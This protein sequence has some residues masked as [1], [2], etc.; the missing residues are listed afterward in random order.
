[1]ELDLLSSSRALSPDSVSSDLDTSLLRDW[2]LDFRASSPNSAASVEKCS[3]S[4]DTMCVQ[5]NR[6]HCNYYLSYSEDR[7]VSPQSSLSE[8][9]FSDVSIKDLFNDSRPESPDLVPSENRF[10]ANLNTGR[11]SHA[12]PFPLADLSFLP[13]VFYYLHHYKTFISTLFDPL[14]K[15][16]SS[17]FEMLLKFHAEQKSFQEPQT[18][19][20][21]FALKRSHEI[22]LTDKFTP[23]KYSAECT[24]LPYFS[25]KC[26]SHSSQE[27]TFYESFSQSHNFVHIRD[28]FQCNQLSKSIS[29]SPDASGLDQ[30][31]F[32]PCHDDIKPDSP[33]FVVFDSVP[34]QNMAIQAFS[35]CN[36][37]PSTHV[38][39]DSVKCLKHKKSEQCLIYESVNKDQRL[40]YEPF[41][42]RLTAHIY[43]PV[44]R[45]KHVCNTVRFSVTDEGFEKTSEQSNV[46]C[47]TAFGEEK[48]IQESTHFKNINSIKPRLNDARTVNNSQPELSYMPSVKDNMDICDT[49]IVTEAFS[50]Q[51]QTRN[52]TME[53]RPLLNE[54]K[55]T[56]T[57][58]PFMMTYSHDEFFKDMPS[59]SLR[60][61]KSSF[62]PVST[63]SSKINLS[64]HKEQKDPDFKCSETSLQSM[65]YHAN[66]LSENVAL[67][68][69]DIFDQS[70]TQSEVSL[71][72]V[73]G[74]TKTME[75]GL[76]FLAQSEGSSSMTKDSPQD[77]G[78][79]E[80][81]TSSNP[82]PILPGSVS[83]QQEYLLSDLQEMKMTQDEELRSNILCP[84]LSQPHDGISKGDRIHECNG[85]QLEVGCPK[86]NLSV[87][88]QREKE[89]I[90]ASITWPTRLPISDQVATEEFS[91]DPTITQSTPGERTNISPTEDLSSAEY[92]QRGHD[93]LKHSLSF[94]SGVG[95]PI[96][97]QLPENLPSD[98]CE[99]YLI[100]HVVQGQE[101]EPNL[102]SCE[103]EELTRRSLQE[104]C[105]EMSDLPNQEA[106]ISARRSS[107]EELIPCS[108]SAKFEISSNEIS[109]V[110]CVH[111]PKTA[112]SRRQVIFEDPMQPDHYLDEVHPKANLQH[113][114]QSVTSVENVPDS[115]PSFV[116]TKTTMTSFTC[117]QDHTIP[118]AISPST[119][120]FTYQD[121]V[122]SGTRG[123][124]SEY[125]DLEHYFDCRQAASDFFEPNEPELTSCSNK[126]LLWDDLS[127]PGEKETVSR[128]VL[129]S[130]GSEDFE[131]ASVV[132]E[133]LPRVSA[134]L[135]SHSEAS[136]EEFT[137]CELPSSKM[138]AYDDTNSLTRAD[139][140]PD[141]PMQTTTEE[142]YKDENG[143]IV[144]RKVTRKIIRKCVS[145]DGAEREEVLIEGSPQR[146]ISVAEGDGYS[147]VVKRTVLKSEGD[148]T[149]VTFAESEGFSASQATAEVRKV[150]LAE[151]TTVV[152]GKRTVTHKGDLSL[153]SDLP[154]A[155]EDFNQALG[156]IGG[157]TREELPYVV[158]S[159]T[160]KDDGTVVRRAH[161]RKGQT[162]RRTVVQGGGQRKQ[163]LLEQTDGPTKGS[164]SHELQQHLHQLFHHYYEHQ[165]DH[166][167]D[168]D[169][170]EAKQS[171]NV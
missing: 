89:N 151:R 5:N 131:D 23:P 69:A 140:M 132:Q 19:S 39:F 41:R 117:D 85:L 125:S 18:V 99:E 54:H 78:E 61:D 16:K 118:A 63:S 126:H 12:S 4:P 112:T 115:Q 79:E 52:E 154:S 170:E 29:V 104:L 119:T 156:Y 45:G 146:S 90:N 96:F 62:L 46:E 107:F 33:K 116:E 66:T 145:S 11:Q 44:Y 129:L 158:E 2:L 135:S 148:H 163:V 10:S 30:K 6:Q 13:P 162:L 51:S 35:D 49:G 38:T 83:L 167:D 122:C 149:E 22:A 75:K 53:Q 40:L 127:Y 130:S 14:Y 3:F 159:E 58:S 92:S 169:D 102:L 91:L 147:K 133:G 86:D 74:S 142:N 123:P 8:V 55:G 43:D 168:D 110:A 103:R 37:I 70:K 124:A 60:M 81:I 67:H 100:S 120:T 26:S 47:L 152:E 1:M 136:T 48:C 157:L 21:C 24:L 76:I 59:E 77:S 20:S 32:G 134:D 141:V 87:R 165:E 25:P 106:D 171:K 56:D 109:P 36:L 28:A 57:L 34:H 150:S 93:I 31:C 153:A 68:I 27:C 121:V 101:Q 71:T 84:P 82:S 42:R 166:D 111:H 15:G 98:V 128:P 160:V 137:L 95:T 114:E 143:H 161:M 105:K 164:K 65:H 88:L 80:I 17:S 9:D 113:M 139:E 64:Q 73:T 108:T 155:Q 94:I 97:P 7:P 144:V 50:K 138:T 72:S